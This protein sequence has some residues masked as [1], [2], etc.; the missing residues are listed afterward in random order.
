[1]WVIKVAIRFATK[2]IDVYILKKQSAQTKFTYKRSLKLRQLPQSML[3]VAHE[4]GR[5]Y[6]YPKGQ[7]IHTRGDSKPGLS[8]IVKGVVKVGNFDLEGRYQ[9][10]AL[11]KEG[12]T[13]GE[14]TLFTD[15]PRTHNATAF[16][17]CEIILINQK[18]FA[19][20]LAKQPIVAQ[21]MLT[22]ISE[23]LHTVLELLDD[24]K[25]LPTHVRLAKVL[26]SLCI[27]QETTNLT[28]R[29]SD[30]AELLG[31]TVLSTHKALKTL[32]NL[33]LIQSYY[34]GI[35][36]SELDRLKRFVSKHSSVLPLEY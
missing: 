22:N 28:I 6:R 21:Y 3:D 19:F 31:L 25:R 32:N 36:V 4:Y 5:M 7:L 2:Y 18:Q 26:L 29:Q 8:I 34:G 17:D 16:S 13:F 12:D 35:A 1:M 11:L 9:L 15:L 23:K 24:I 33:E 14:F 20:W 27:E 10:T 30:C